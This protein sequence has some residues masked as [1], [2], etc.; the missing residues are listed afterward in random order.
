MDQK[1]RT[2]T[3]GCM[4]GAV[5]YAAAGTPI[6]VAYCHCRS[7]RQ[8]TGA[9][10]VAFV[11]FE[12]KQVEYVK[13]RRKIYHSSP[14]V[15]RAFCGD[16]GTPLSWEGNSLSAAGTHITE[17]HISTLDEPDRF[18]PELHWFDEERLCWFETADV[19]PRY[20]QLDGN[21]VKPCRH[22]PNKE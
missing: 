3:G 11:A 4:C 14:G 17:F 22:G 9:P 15:G 8:H 10:L 12:T 16:C 6:T 7:C 20:A 18:P 21:G 1:T 2:A 5:R 19:L 13:G